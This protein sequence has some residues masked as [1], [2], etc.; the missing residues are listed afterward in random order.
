MSFLLIESVGHHRT[1]LVDQLLRL[2]H[3]IECFERGLE[4]QKT[5]LVVDRVFPNQSPPQF[6][7]LSAESF[8]R[9]R[10]SFFQKNYSISRKDS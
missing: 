8:R 9:S 7:R 5:S 3:P 6:F 1:L 2:P 10:I 4:K